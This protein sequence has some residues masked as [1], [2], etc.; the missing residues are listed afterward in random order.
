MRPFHI[1]A[2]HVEIWT[3]VPNRL[4]V[5]RHIGICAGKGCTR[6][7]LDGARGGR[8]ADSHTLEAVSCGHIAHLDCVDPCPSP[9]VIAGG[10]VEH[11]PPVMTDGV[12]LDFLCWRSATASS[13]SS[14]VVVERTTPTLNCDISSWKLSMMACN[15]LT[16]AETVGTTGSPGGAVNGC[17]SLLRQRLLQPPLSFCQKTFLLLLG[18]NSLPGVGCVLSGPFHALLGPRN[19]TSR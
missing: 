1:C 4:G 3:F 9:P 15:R 12:T 2:N 8:F 17:R 7:T 13:S 14:S 19:E 10:I 5:G 18:G 16:S 6:R 11:A